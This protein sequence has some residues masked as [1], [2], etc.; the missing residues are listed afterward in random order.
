MDLGLRFLRRVFPLAVTG[1]IRLILEILKKNWIMKP[2][3]ALL[4]L[5][6]ALLSKA[7][8]NYAFIEE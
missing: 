8:S 4:L 1:I 6:K 5:R 2:T 3:A 7:K